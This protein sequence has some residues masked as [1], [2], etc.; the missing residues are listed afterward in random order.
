MADDDKLK[1]LKKE[2]GLRTDT[3]EVTPP[4]E[5]A[6]AGPSGPQAA[7]P[8][9]AADEPIVVKTSRGPWVVALV[10]LL[11][12]GLGAGY[13]AASV[14]ASRRVE[15]YRTEDARRLLDFLRSHKMPDASKPT[16]EL[17]ADHRKAIVD[18][19][20]R[21]AKARKQGS[22]R[23]ALPQVL[24]FIKHCEDYD[25]RIDV[26][27]VLGD[28]FYAADV[29]PPLVHFLS[30]VDQLYAETKGLVRM[31]SV[32]GYV[33]HRHRERAKD[34]HKA[35]ARYLIEAVK[36]PPAQGPPPLPRAVPIDAM[37][38]PSQLPDGR[39]AVAVRE[40]GKEKGVLVELQR[41]AVV[42]LNP[43]YDAIDSALIEFVLARIADAVAHMAETSLQADSSLLERALD[44]L[45]KRP[46][47]FT[48]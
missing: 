29:V 1:Q 39:W 28:A 14:F 17:I 9:A 43:I 2:L 35:M 15:N 33:V 7:S 38:D 46:H 40:K 47:Y 12:L 48:F 10:A 42:D 41:I 36:P 45:A 37:K 13:F 27:H 20:Q 34:P 5:S 23:D 4:T 32:L 11:L 26:G 3:Q 25:A 22:L 21:L 44:K 30:G 24:A 31:A 8:G 16:L 6:P 18:M 19:A